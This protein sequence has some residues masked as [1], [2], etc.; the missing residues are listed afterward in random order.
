MSL[1][2]R[3]LRR[4]TVQWVAVEALGVLLFLLGIV[5]YAAPVGN[6]LLFEVWIKNLDIGP[7]LVGLC[8]ALIWRVGGTLRHGVLAETARQ[9]RAIMAEFERRKQSG[10]EDALE[11]LTRFQDADSFRTLRRRAA[12]FAFVFGLV[13]ILIIL[14]AALAGAIWSYAESGLDTVTVALAGFSVF[15]MLALV[16]HI[17]ERPRAG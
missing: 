12:K 8:G 16:R 7:A 6:G 15:G 9:D 14:T 17:W 5:M 10:K 11:F 13:G 4:R 1:S 3:Q 2:H